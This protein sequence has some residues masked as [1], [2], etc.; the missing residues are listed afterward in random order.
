MLLIYEPRQDFPQ[1][2]DELPLL[3][4]LKEHIVY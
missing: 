2:G 1:S 3:S 4:W